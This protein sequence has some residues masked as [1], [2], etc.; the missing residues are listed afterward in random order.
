MMRLFLVCSI[1]FL[2]FRS[3]A[4]FKESDFHCR[5]DSVISQTS[6][7]SVYITRDRTCALYDWLCP[8]PKNWMEEHDMEEN[9]PELVNF[10]NTQQSLGSLPRYWN[11]LYEYQGKYY[12]YGPS[13]WMGNS[14][15]YISDSFLVE[16]TSDITYFRIK[17]TEVIRSSEL[18]LTVDLYGEEATLRIRLL[19]TP[20]GAS[21][22]E[23][24]IKNESW[25][26]LKV[27]SDFVRG[28]D[29]INNDCVNQKCY[30]EF[31]FDEIDLSRLKFA[32]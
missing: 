15:D 14:P 30:Q 20:E 8:K 10:L 12:V 25:S 22:W 28:Y 32:D 11:N 9:F 4:Q 2:Q 13:D 6:Y 1:L 21:L 3:F 23:Y 24:K 29:L 27:S 26:E 16:I 7:G 31:H 17:K 19:A 5:R 18:L